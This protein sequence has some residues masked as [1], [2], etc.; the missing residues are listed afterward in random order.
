MSNKPS[1]DFARDSI[2][3][4]DGGRLIALGF[5]EDERHSHVQ[6]APSRRGR[7][8]EEWL[9]GWT[10]QAGRA[11][12]HGIS[13][14]TISD[15]RHAVV[16]LLRA[17]GYTPRWKSWALE[18][19]LAREPDPPQLPPGYAIRN[20]VPDSG[21]ERA[22]HRV[23]DDAFADWPEWQR[24]PFEEWAA[25]TLGRPGFTPQSIALVAHADEVA[26]AAVL[27]DDET[28]GWVDQLAVAR[29]H[30]GRGLARA[31]LLHAF[32]IA[33]RA[34]KTRCGLSTDSRT[35]ALGL[36]ERIGMRVRR[37][38]TQYAKPL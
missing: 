32:G 12:G 21:D 34:G 36:Y 1:F 8:I 16:Q 27:I 9:L 31:L 28:M 33:W 15:A 10:Q 14:Q 29:A 5:L 20:L 35:G 18:I 19:E 7:G 13:G 30:R 38:Y 23:I 11:A 25:E 24:R 17:D 6:V 3:V 37:S 22:V 4:R 2:G 26:G